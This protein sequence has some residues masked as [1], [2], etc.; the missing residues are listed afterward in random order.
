M[1]VN[2]PKG[3]K[4]NIGGIYVHNKTNNNITITIN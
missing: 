2:I 3:Y 4:V 1:K